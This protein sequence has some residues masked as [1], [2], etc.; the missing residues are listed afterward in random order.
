MERDQEGLSARTHQDSWLEGDGPTSELI[1][2]DGRLLGN[3]S[4]ESSSSVTLSM[5]P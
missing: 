5:T 4:V 2:V 1:H 3:T